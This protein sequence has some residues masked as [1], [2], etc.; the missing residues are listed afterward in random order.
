MGAGQGSRAREET[1]KEIW[2]QKEMSDFATL[3]E[4]LAIEG[5][6]YT[7]EQQS[8]VE[9]L[10]PLVSDLIRK[11]GADV[12]M[13]ID[14][15]VEAN[16]NGYASVVKLVTCDVVARVMRQST[17]GDPMSQEAQSALGYSWSGTY[18][19][20]GGGVTMSLMRNELKTLGIRRQRYGVMDIW[21]R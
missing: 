19:I 15:L 10:L 8:R 17:T 20:P 13:D 9:S 4:V 21:E 7:L 5:V 18:A 14:A 16:E 1:C 3:E 11:A 2:R 6:T 12:G